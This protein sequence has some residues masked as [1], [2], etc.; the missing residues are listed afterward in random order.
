MRH[1]VPE[2]AAGTAAPAT[3]NVAAA[4]P[5]GPESGAPSARA[6]VARRALLGA[7]MLGI[8]ADPLLRDAP[9]GLGLLVWMAAFAAV[10]VALLRRAGR[11]LSRE[12]GIWLAVAILCAAGLSWRDAAML[13]FFDVLAMLAALVLLAMSISAVPVPGLVP[14]RVR[15]LIRA[16]FGTGIDVAT[17]VVPLLLFDAELHAAPRRSG[18]GSARRIG[19]ALLITAPVLIVFTLLLARA[20]PVFGSIFSF[21]DLDL[22]VAFSHVAVAGFFAWVVAGWLRRSLLARPGA[23]GIPATPLPLTLG[24]TDVALVLGALNVLFAAFVLVQVGWL[25]GGEALVLRTTGLTYADYARRGFFELMWVAALLLPVLLG[26]R[27]LV[28]DPDARTLRIYR[29]LALSLVVLLGAILLS[30]GARMRLYV[31]YYGISTD[32]LYATA[33]MTWLAMVFAW[34][35]FTVLRSRPRTFAAGLV[36]SGFAVLLTLNLMNPDA[37]VARA[38]LARGPSSLTGS[39]GPD[40]R[41]LASLGGDAVPM[42]VSALAAPAVAADTATAGDRCAAADIVVRRWTGEQRARMTGNWTQWNAARSRATR[43]VRAHEAGLRR[44]ACPRS[45]DRAAT[46]P[47]SP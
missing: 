20:D 13:Q 43:A 29:R 1:P 21:A 19:R 36:A 37:L 7:A 39:T 25:F 35:T 24:V 11:P 17:G 34:L 12:S 27:A 8:L 42:L 14:A 31:Q 44:L 23:A 41:Y 46:R 30:A 2:I 38:N 18:N 40:L 4:E 32:R 26:A 15:D 3:S 16:A 47:A 45:G 28:P 9:W 33:V 10:V 22:G 6:L 5:A